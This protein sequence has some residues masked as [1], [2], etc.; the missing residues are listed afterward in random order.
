MP[1]LCLDPESM[2]TASYSF[3]NGLHKMPGYFAASG[4][5]DMVMSLSLCCS[6]SRI[7][8]AS[9]LAFSFLSFSS[10]CLSLRSSKA[11]SFC[12]SFASF[13][14]A[15]RSVPLSLTWSPKY[16]GEYMR[17]RL[18]RFAFLTSACSREAATDRSVF[19]GP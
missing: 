13:F 2:K 9:F 6:F 12:L 5:R 19:G 4:G 7:T 15:A 16:F 14:L 17:V 10:L 3:R 18:S 1:S 11:F 8:S